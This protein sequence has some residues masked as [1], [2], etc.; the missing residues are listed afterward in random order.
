MHLHTHIHIHT[1]MHAC[2]HTYLHTHTYDMAHTLDTKGDP[3]ALGRFSATSRTPVVRSR[4]TARAS[5]SQDLQRSIRAPICVFC[6]LAGGSPGVSGR[7][8]FQSC[9]C[10]AVKGQRG[11]SRPRA[12]RTSTGQQLLIVFLLLLFFLLLCF[13]LLACFAVSLLSY[14]VVVRLCACVCVCVFVLCVVISLFV[15]LP[16]ACCFG[17]LLHIWHVFWPRQKGATSQSTTCRL[18]PYPFRR[19]PNFLVTGSEAQNK[20]PLKGMG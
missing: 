5:K 20:V 8:K 4:C 6:S 14:F 1:C 18:I 3:G 7:G 13:V 12:W 17:S 16:R 2:I 11:S 19:L 10:P 15:R 9:F